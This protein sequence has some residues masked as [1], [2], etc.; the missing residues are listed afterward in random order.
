MGG[1]RALIALGIIRDSPRSVS[2]SVA[3]T[4]S[5]QYIARGV[6]S[7]VRRGRLSKGLGSPEAIE[8]RLAF[9]T[10]L[11]SL[12]GACDL[13]DQHWLRSTWLVGAGSELSL[14]DPQDCSSSRSRADDRQLWQ[15]AA[16][17]KPDAWDPAL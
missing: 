3:P 16:L 9:G 17:H 13:V 15:G 11:A 5:K 14:T 8:E 10:D 6:A 4:G 12:A 7:L 1:R 2:V